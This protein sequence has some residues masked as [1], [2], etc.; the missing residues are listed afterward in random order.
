MFCHHAAFRTQGWPEEGRHATTTSH[1]QRGSCRTP[2]GTR[3]HPTLHVS[4][5]YQQT[6]TVLTP[7]NPSLE[8]NIATSRA[9][10]GSC[11]TP[12][13]T[14]F[15]PAEHVPGTTGLQNIG[16]PQGWPDGVTTTPHA[17]RGSCWTPEGTQLHPTLH[18]FASLRPATN[19]KA[20]QVRR[21]HSM[22]N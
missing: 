20:A 19:A 1:T 2:E 5:S 22:P 6:S 17:R 9:R 15:Q 8:G 14:R 11:R 13:G 21:R 3:L 7:E 10:R 4:S 18:A 16:L 12:K